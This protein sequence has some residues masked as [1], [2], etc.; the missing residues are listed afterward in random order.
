[1]S[2]TGT[3]RP[4]EKNALKHKVNC[5]RQQRRFAAQRVPQCVCASCAY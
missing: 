5:G 2:A 4:E 3:V 1:M